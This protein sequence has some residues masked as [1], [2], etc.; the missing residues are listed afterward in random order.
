LLTDEN[1]AQYH[2]WG[3]GTTER[4]YVHQTSEDSG[5]SHLSRHL[6]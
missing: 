1:T 5:C 6:S 2:W 3:V 4:V